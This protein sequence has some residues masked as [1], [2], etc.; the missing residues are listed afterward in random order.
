MELLE[1]GMRLTTCYLEVGLRRALVLI[2]NAPSRE[3]ENQSMRMKN[4]R[5]ARANQRRRPT[6][7]WTPGRLTVRVD[8]EWSWRL[9]LSA[10]FVVAAAWRWAYLAR[11]RHTPFAGSLDADAR[12]YWD[13]S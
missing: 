1:T 8:R 5:P 2:A 4:R 10:L 7:S 12:V 13:W 9:G 11:L 3:V 6:P